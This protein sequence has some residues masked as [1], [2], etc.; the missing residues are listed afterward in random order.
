MSKTKKGVTIE[1]RCMSGGCVM[2][3][4]PEKLDY[5]NKALEELWSSGGL[6]KAM[7]TDLDIFITENLPDEEPVWANYQDPITPSVNAL[8]GVSNAILLDAD[9]CEYLHRFLIVCLR[10]KQYDLLYMFFDK[11]FVTHVCNTV[12]NSRNAQTYSLMERSFDRFVEAIKFSKTDVKELVPALFDIMNSYEGQLYS[13]WQR[14]ARDFLIDYTNQN[15]ED[16]LLFLNKNFEKYGLQ[17][18]YFLSKIDLPHSVD[19]AINLFLESNEYRDI[20][21]EFLQNNNEYS[22]KT[23]SKMLHNKQIDNKQYVDI[24]LVFVK[25]QT[26]N[27]MFTQIFF[28]IANDEQKAKILDFIPI[29]LEKRIKTLASFVKTINRYQYDDVEVLGKKLSQYPSVLQVS[30]DIAPENTTQY[31]ITQF[32]NL[33]SPKATYELSYFREMLSQKTLNNLS[34]DIYEQ[35]VLYGTTD[36]VWAIALIASV[37]SDDSLASILMTTADLY[38]GEKCDIVKL[39]IDITV[40][41]KGKEIEEVLKHLDKHNQNYDKVIS[42]ILESVEANKVF[43][44]SEFQDLADGLV[45]TFDLDENLCTTITFDDFEF[46]FVIDDNCEVNIVPK[47]HSLESV[48][49]TIRQKVTDYQKRIQN[50]LAKQT[51]RLY[52]AFCNDRK[53]TNEGFDNLQKN[54]ILYALSRGILWAEYSLDKVIRTFKIEGHQKIKIMDINNINMSSPMIGVFHPLEAPEYNWK[55]AFNGKYVAFNQLDRQV[56][57]LDSYTPLSSFV[58]RFNGMIVDGNLFVKQLESSGWIKGQYLKP[59]GLV[60]MVK[61]SPVNNLICE[62]EFCANHLDDLSEI[63]VKEL[64]FYNLNSTK[65]QNN[66]WKTDKVN[67]KALKTLPPRYFSDI[68]YEVSVACKK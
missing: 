19:L 51:E 14:P 53:W 40:V 20:I 29:K 10:A 60:S 16:F 13:R 58:A 49:K 43:D 15:E 23:I 34:K 63:T 62:I 38:E 61:L 65:Y 6:N 7:A 67:A 50:E 48:G 39:L 18:L 36:D 54:P 30:D 31:L 9:F 52:M 11:A 22:I 2:Q 55:A 42:L 28:T 8:A 66:I 33:Y 32:M 41:T 59:F 46:G 24:M 12:F 27:E 47:S 37:T 3:I 68:V 1:K 45:P 25:Q 64:R 5:L 44:Y 21:A 56:Y 35:Y 26:L 17:G 4:R 57:S